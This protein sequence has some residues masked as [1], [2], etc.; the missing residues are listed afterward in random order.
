MI[1][2]EKNLKSRRFTALIA[3]FAVAVLLFSTVSTAILAE[4]EQSNNTATLL[5]EL[6]DFA[7]GAENTSV[8]EWINGSLSRSPELNEWYAIGISK[9][10]PDAD[11]TPYATALESYLQ[12]AK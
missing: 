3:I 8:E 1:S 11:L 5:K 9:L 10:H 2:A 12:N 7:A 6:T 4:S